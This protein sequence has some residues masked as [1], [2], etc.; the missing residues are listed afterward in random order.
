MEGLIDEAL[1]TTMHATRC[2]SSTALQ[3]LSPGAVVFCRDMF[4]DLAMYADILLLQKHCQQLVD[5]RLLQASSQSI[6][7]DYKVG[8]QVLK[9]AVLTFSDKL[10]TVFAGTFPSSLFIL[11][12][13]L[14]FGWQTTPLSG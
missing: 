8:N 14:P 12:V 7:H 11:M 1:S 10:Q 3:G 2:T 5:E 9:K 13:L 6:Q 4:L